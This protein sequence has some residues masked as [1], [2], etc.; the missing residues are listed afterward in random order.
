MV[1]CVAVAHWTGS[2]WLD[3]LD[4]AAGFASRSWILRMFPVVGELVVLVT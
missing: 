3:G 4:P 2:G 1:V